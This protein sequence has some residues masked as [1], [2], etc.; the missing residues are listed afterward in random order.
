[1]GL[2]AEDEIQFLIKAGRVSPARKQN[3]DFTRDLYY[4]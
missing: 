3:F 2:Q 4:A 1:M